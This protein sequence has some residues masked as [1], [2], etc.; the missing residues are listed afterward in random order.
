MTD[1]SHFIKVIF[2]SIL[3]YLLMS[4]IP[5]SFDLLSLLHEC[6]TRSSSVLKLLCQLVI[7]DNI[8]TRILTDEKK[9][10]KPLDFGIEGRLY[11]SLLYMPLLILVR[12]AS[13]DILW[14]KSI[15]RV[16]CLCSVYSNQ[17]IIY[18]HTGGQG[19]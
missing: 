8:Q 14:E 15:N 11:P 10:T 17:A 12:S 1:N 19:S 4:C 5:L 6:L 18:A 3:H 9:T 16:C 2:T 7:P 13:G